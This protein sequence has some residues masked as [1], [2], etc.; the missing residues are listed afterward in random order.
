MGLFDTRIDAA[1]LRRHAKANEPI[2]VFLRVKGNG[3][4]FR[5]VRVVAVLEDGA[6]FEARDG[7][8]TTVPLKAVHDPDKLQSRRRWLSGRSRASEISDGAE[9]IS[10]FLLP[11]LN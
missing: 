5:G 8:R 11:W 6:E 7:S 9:A 2:D 3:K 10:T 1:V 4:I